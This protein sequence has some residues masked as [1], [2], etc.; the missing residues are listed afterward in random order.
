MSFRVTVES[1]LDVVCIRG[2]AMRTTNFAHY[3]TSVIFEKPLHFHTQLTP[4]YLFWHVSFDDVVEHPDDEVIIFGWVEFESKEARDLANEK[5]ATDP[6]MAGFDF[7]GSGF[8]AS[9]MVYGGFRP[10]K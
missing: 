9:R 6:R 8:D 3:R 2:V 4:C 7:E 10:N 5:V 1:V